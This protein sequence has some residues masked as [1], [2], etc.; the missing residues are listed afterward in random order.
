[1]RAIAIARRHNH[2]GGWC[3]GLAQAVEMM[4]NLILGMTCLLAVA[5]GS[6]DPE[7]SPEEAL[8]QW[9]LRGELAAEEKDRGQLLDMIS[10][11]YVDSRGNDFERIDNLLRAYF[12]RQNSIAL[13]TS[14]DDIQVM[15]ETAA[16][17]NITVGMAGTQ[18]T[19]IGINADAY[20]FE[21]ELEKVDDEWLLIGSRW[22]KLG[23]ELR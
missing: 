1:M 20:N 6:S 15:G 9:V 11:D 23:G 12:F 21:F 16:L 2:E 22:G 10:A 18:D 8:R 14:I 17:V 13:L 4:R 19:R 7:G 3:H 5:C